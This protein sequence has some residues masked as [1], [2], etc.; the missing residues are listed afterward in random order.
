MKRFAILMV[1]FILGIIILSCG[2]DNPLSSD[3]KNDVFYFNSFEADKDSS[4][5]TGLGL[6]KDMFANDPCPEDGKRSLHIGG[7][8]P[9]PAASI[10]LSP[11]EEGN[12]K[13]SFWAK[14]GQQSQSAQVI[15]KTCCDTESQDKLVVL[16]DSTN[17]KHYQS[18]GYL[19]VPA[20]KKLNLEIWV[21]GIVYADVFIDNLKI[22]KIS[23]SPRMANIY[24]NVLG[25]FK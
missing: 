4:G 15:L 17:W 2:E 12:Y 13:F 22:E 1:V 20:N 7:G 24:E 23:S 11:V 6:S 16:V 5:W 3:N 21:G 19:H 10:E 18:E 14:M 8:C 25:V 9:Q